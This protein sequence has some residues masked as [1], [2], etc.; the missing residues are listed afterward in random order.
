MGTMLTL[1][2][3]I[4]QRFLFQVEDKYR[5]INTEIRNNDIF[6]SEDLSVQAP[7]ATPIDNRS[8]P[9]VVSPSTDNH[10]SSAAPSKKKHHSKHSNK[11]PVWSKSKPTKRKGTR[12]SETDSPSLRLALMSSDI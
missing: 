3:K 8:S 10:A 2:A 9:L 4:E 5:G 6:S 12:I 7:A 1:Q 11:S